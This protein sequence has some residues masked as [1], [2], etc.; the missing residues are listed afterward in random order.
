[1]R[2]C[3]LVKSGTDD[4]PLCVILGTAVYNCLMQASEALWTGNFKKAL[5][6]TGAQNNPYTINTFVDINSYIDKRN[7]K[8]QGTLYFR[9]CGVNMFQYGNDV[10]DKS[11]YMGLVGE[12]TLSY[13]TMAKQIDGTS[14]V[15]LSN[16]NAA[17][18]KKTTGVS[19]TKKYEVLA[20][21]TL[22]IAEGRRNRT[23]LLTH[24]LLMDLIEDQTPFGQAGR[25]RTLR[26]AIDVS[27]AKAEK[28][29]SYGTSAMGDSPLSHEGAVKDSRTSSNAEDTGDS[30]YKDK[31][32]SLAVQWVVAHFASE[33]FHIESC[34]PTD[35]RPGALELKLQDYLDLQV[36]NL[37]KKGRETK[38]VFASR[39]E[40]TKVQ[41]RGKLENSV[42]NT[43]L[44]YIRTMFDLRL[45]FAR[46]TQETAASF[47][48]MPSTDASSLYSAVTQS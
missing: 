10:T 45:T 28:L 9:F 34:K 36:Q 48:A 4:V 33:E 3:L 11:Y 20:L 15:A 35:L 16:V 30:R 13:P 43:V 19:T 26:R 44:A 31:T 18:V 22:F 21:A 47:G 37:K 42:K 32:I 5:A 23:T 17:N 8:K 27:E 2:T 46:G 41:N 25:K 6:G 40:A 38:V 12:D 24:L 1:M 14:N 7:E 39:V 29:K